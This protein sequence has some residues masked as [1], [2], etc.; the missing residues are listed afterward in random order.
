MVSKMFSDF[1][2]TFI[3][4]KVSFYKW[5]YSIQNNLISYDQTPYE[6]ELKICI[7]NCIISYTSEFKS[8]K[9]L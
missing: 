3:N 7:V 8:I 6:I 9:N 2:M 4:T 1:Q 5:L